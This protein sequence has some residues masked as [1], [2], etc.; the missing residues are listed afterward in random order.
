M[1]YEEV[2]ALR[3]AFNSVKERQSLNPPSDFEERKKRLKSSRELCVGNE[4]LLSKAIDNLRRNGIK[5]YPVR[6]KQE[7]VDVILDEAGHEKHIVKSKSNVTKEIE[8]TR[9][10][11]RKGL[12]VIETDIGDRILQILNARP[13]HPTGPVTHLS[14]REI[15]KK[16]S[17]Y[18][19][20]PIKESPEEI[21]QI[22]RED[23]ISNLNDARVGITGANA[24]TVEEGSI[25]MTHNEGN[26]YEVMRKEKHIVV[27]SIDKIYPDI[28]AAMNM[29][30]ILSFSATGSIVPSFVEVISGVSKTADVEK[31][32]IKG[33]HNPS[34]IVLVLLDNRR[35]E[36]AGNGFKDLLL[37]IGCG[38]CL[39][40]CPMYN[41]IGNE[42]A[43]DNYLGGKGLAYY[44]LYNNEKDERLEFC[45]TCGR[46]KENCP[47]GLDIPAIIKRIRSKGISSDIYYF[48]K[49]H[50][51]W[52]YYQMLLRLKTANK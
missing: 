10:L 25:M 11:E 33:I 51:I 23:V 49:S 21:V 39:L 6:E 19:N 2:I 7:A 32:F 1:H 3:K 9:A 31:K 12:T 47:L 26:I 38:N 45:L 30:K 29:I 24:I 46:C 43:R 42:F 15:A 14:A 13:S 36:L 40:H 28:E 18:Y 17:T 41:T 48:L 52:A 44:S 8:L 16:L 35:T 5:V 27:T 4:I 50:M 37:C 34:E 20:K 22:V